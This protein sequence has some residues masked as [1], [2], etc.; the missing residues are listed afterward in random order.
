MRLY[1]K[2]DGSP[3]L[4][5][6]TLATFL[7]AG[8]Y[9]KAFWFTTGRVKD[10]TMVPYF[11]TGGFPFAD[12]V[13]YQQFYLIKEKLQGKIVAVQNPYKKNEIIFRRIIAEQNQWV[14]RIDDGGIIKVP[15][16]HVWVE[17]INPNDRGVDS[18]STFGPISKNFVVGKAWYVIWP[19]WRL[20]SVN[21][22]D[23]YSKLTNYKYQHSKVFSEEEMFKTYGVR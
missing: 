1:F 8:V 23:K 6:L 19:L 22:L 13:L 18:L 20:E 10:D 9:F 5:N 14:Q 17:S 21:D 7:L 15:N 11:R 16:N 2:A 3:N 4:K 12:R